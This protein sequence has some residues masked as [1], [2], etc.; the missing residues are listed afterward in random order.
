VVFKKEDHSLVLQVKDNGIGFEID[1]ISK[2]QSFG[3]L[4][5]SE[6]ALSIGGQLSI[7]SIKD[8]GTTVNLE[9]R[10]RN[11]KPNHVIA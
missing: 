9:I 5:M 1:K 8:I 7:D 4:G 6:R 2:V 10:E 3:I 11:D